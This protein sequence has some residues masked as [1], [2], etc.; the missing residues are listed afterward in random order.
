MPENRPGRGVYV[1]NETGGD[2]DHGQPVAVDN[3]VGIAVKQK[4]IHWDEALSAASVIPD[5]E[6]F[7]LIDKGVVLVDAVSTP[8][9]GEAIYITG[10]NALTKTKEGNTAFGRIYEIAG[11]RGVPTGKMRVDLDAKDSL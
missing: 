11:E 10:A 2:L 9:K 8:K 3:Y 4:A 5:E 7:F 6:D 1:T